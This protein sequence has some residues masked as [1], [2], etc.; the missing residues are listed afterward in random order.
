MPGS[1]RDTDVL[2]SLAPNDTEKA[3]RAESLMTAGG[4]ISVQVLNEF[5]HVARRKMRLSWPETL[6]FLTVIRDLLTIRP[7]TLAVHDSG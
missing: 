5:T 3:N 1:F 6:A 4:T 7:T 2:L